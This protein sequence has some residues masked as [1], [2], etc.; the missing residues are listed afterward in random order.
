GREF[1][2]PTEVL[3]MVQTTRGVVYSD[4]AGDVWAAT[5]DSAATKVGTTARR[6]PRLVADGPHAAWSSPV[7]DGR[8]AWNVL[9]HGTGELV[10]LDGDADSGEFTNDVQ[11]I[12]GTTL[13]LRDARGLVAW[14][15]AAD[16]STVL[17]PWRDNL[18]V[19]DVEDGQ[20]AHLY[21]A[22]RSARTLTF[23]VG[24]ALGQGEEVVL[25]NGLD[26]SPDGRR[27]LGESEPDSFAV[28]DVASGL[29][30]PIKP[31]G[32]SFFIGYR[33]LDADTYLG[34]GLNQP[35]E[36]TPVDLLRCD[37]GGGCSAA[38]VGI[39]TV[40]AGFVLPIGEPMDG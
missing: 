34:L 15:F 2:V 35:W 13:Y 4:A 21:A 7:V 25:W 39:G 10:S 1:E 18:E 22:T 32:Y 23:R 36:S 6:A 16:T 11:A 29:A 5:G 33:W 37:V 12:D 9:D 40:D 24:P 30:Q 8:G 28:F 27:V 14:D 3:A 31:E 20:I 38:A 26:L 17:G 19:V